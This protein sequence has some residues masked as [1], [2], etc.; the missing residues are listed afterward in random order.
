MKSEMFYIIDTCVLLHK[1]SI[2]RVMEE[3]QRDGAELIVPQKVHEEL[4]GLL[5]REK[6]RAAVVQA[7]QLV[8][9]NKWKP[10]P[11]QGKF[12]T[13]DDE[14]LSYCR[15][16]SA[17]P[18]RVYTHDRG[19]K[20]KLTDF[21]SQ[22]DLCPCEPEYDYADEEDYAA[23]YERE[24]ALMEQMARYRNPFDRDDSLLIDRQI[25]D[26]LNND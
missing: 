24:L 22:V 10:L 12:P 16:H 17:A 14:I 21:C 26:Y 7:Q 15:A 25:W 23:A 18:L 20:Q 11:Q 19:L 13:A 4:Y 2:A 5:K 1:E 9:R 3:A 6:I 8:A